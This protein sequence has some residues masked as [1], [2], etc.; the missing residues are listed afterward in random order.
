MDKILTPKADKLPI[1]WRKLALLGGSL[2]MLVVLGSGRSDAGSGFGMFALLPTLVVLGLALLTRRTLEPL[3]AGALV[4]F[5]MVDPGRT[6]HGFVASSLLIMQ[7]PIMGWLILVCGLLGSLIALLQ[8]SGST[9]A[10]SNTL[11][12]YIKHRSHALMA[13]W[14]LGI[15]IFIDDYLNALTVSTAMRKLSDKLRISRDMLAYVVDSTSAP[16]C[17]IIPFST[18]VIYLAGLIEANGL[19]AE[20]EGF[21]YYLS[22]LPYLIYPW[23]ALLLVP[24]VAYGVVPLFGTMKQAE[25]DAAEGKNLPL[26]QDE[27]GHGHPPRLLNFVLP[28]LTLL[29]ATWYFDIDA[30]MGVCCALLV[31][32]VLYRLQGL[33]SLPRL[34]DE[35]IQGVATMLLP[36]GIVFAAFVLQDVNEQLGLASYLID[37]ITPY[38]NAGWLPALSF[39][40]L[41]GLTF[42]TGSFW[43]VYAIAFPIMVPLALSLDANMPLTLG[44]L[45]SAGAFGS[46][47]CFFGDSTVISARGCGISP[48]QHALSQLP[49]TLIAATVTTLLLWLLA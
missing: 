40:V 9:L 43:G 1:G 36:L 18:W 16:V 35:I 33:A 22:L 46:H 48:M 28:V 10:F 27:P 6:L 17:L 39:L 14:L 15:A 19:V 20:G 34:F 11:G 3:L 23:V 45:I 29:L 13:S 25:Q 2:L 4:G 7:G 8:F 37:T 26:E 42:A 32:L 41:A 49:Y 12:R 21:A 31:C 44:A 30:L 24:L 38:M 47:A 5:T